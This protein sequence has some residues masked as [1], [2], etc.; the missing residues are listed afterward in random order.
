MAQWVEAS[1]VAAGMRPKDDPWDIFK[2]NKNLWEA[3]R[4]LCTHI[5]RRGAGN[6]K[7]TGLSSQ[8]EK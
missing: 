8:R 6:P 5:S 2:T 7:H 4:F 1:V 3:Q